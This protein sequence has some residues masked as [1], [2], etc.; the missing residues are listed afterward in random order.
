M[1]A[2]SA[3]VNNTFGPGNGITTRSSIE[4]VIEKLSSILRADIA[5]G[6]FEI[7]VTGTDGKAGFTDVIISA[8]KKFRFVIPKQ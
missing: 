7:T 1:K 2:T 6:H 8:G 3:T 5:H 4:D